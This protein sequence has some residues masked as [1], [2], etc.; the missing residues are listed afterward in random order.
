[1][2]R[3]EIAAHTLHHEKKSRRAAIG[4]SRQRVFEREGKPFTGP[5]ALVGKIGSEFIGQLVAG[6]IENDPGWRNGQIEGEMGGRV[7][8]ADELVARV[9]TRQIED[10]FA[11]MEADRYR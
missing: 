9:G 1:M 10:I 5:R 2:F 6:K 3:V 4:Q 8:D 11:A 7:W